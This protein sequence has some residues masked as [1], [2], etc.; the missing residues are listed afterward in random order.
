MSAVA[1]RAADLFLL[2]AGGPRTNAEVEQALAVD[3]NTAATWLTTWHARGLIYIESHRSLDSGKA[4]APARVWAWQP[5][6]ANPLPD[7]VYTR[8][9]SER[10]RTRRHRQ[11]KKPKPPRTPFNNAMRI[12]QAWPKNNSP[13]T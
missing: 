10:M 4:A 8:L 12:L 3:R 13:I 7:H 2:F 9:T 1:D 11:P 5:D 6:P